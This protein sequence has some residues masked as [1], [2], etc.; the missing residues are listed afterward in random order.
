MMGLGV[1]EILVLVVMVLAIAIVIFFGLSANASKGSG[2]GGGSRRIEGRS[3]ELPPFGA[4]PLAL[5]EGEGDEEAGEGWREDDLSAAPSSSQRVLRGIVRGLELPQLDELPI[6]GAPIEA[7]AALWSDDEEDE[8]PVSF[9]GDA[10]MRLLLDGEHPLYVATGYLSMNEPERRDPDEYG[11]QGITSHHHAYGDIG[12]VS[13]AAGQAW[14]DAIAAAMGIELPPPRRGKRRDELTSSDFFIHGYTQ[15]GGQRWYVFSVGLGFAGTKRLYVEVREDGA[16]ARVWPD[17]APRYHAEVLTDLTA[18]LR[19]GEFAR[20][21]T[22]SDEQL[23]RDAPLV[24]ELPPC[25]EGAVEDAYGFRAAGGRVY[26]ATCDYDPEGGAPEDVVLR[27]WDDLSRAPT[28]RVLTQAR[29]VY[30]EVSRDGQRVLLMNEPATVQVWSTSGVMLHD[31]ELPEDTDLECYVCFSPAGDRVASIAGQ[32]GER[33][34]R[35]LGLR[36]EV[37]AESEAVRGELELVGWIGDEI[38]T[39]E[40]EPEPSAGEVYV[41]LGG[42]LSWSPPLGA[43]EPLSERG[44][45][46][47][48]GTYRLR[49]ERYGF[50]IWEHGVKLSERPIR[51]LKDFK[52]LSGEDHYPWLWLDEHLVIVDTEFFEVFDVRTGRAALLLSAE[53]ED[54][55]YMIEA[56]GDRIVL[57]YDGGVPR[58]ARVEVPAEMEAGAATSA[59]W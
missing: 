31:F 18:R 43:L 16:R 3:H 27:V 56:I 54:E 17:D 21:T 8:A 7:E 4:A 9:S 55:F 12:C 6:G 41:S 46:G 58:W 49:H 25:V 19:D 13:R 38:I 53:H 36:G 52:R 39:E 14:L 22:E 44:W 29:C 1:I 50:S 51:T 45:P 42:V 5:T 30:Q 28:S 20:P 57:L 35:V 34:A 59:A 26:L 24:R 15:R 33:F 23:M 40:I 10:L 32:G 11:E 2:S 48:G 47:E 37:I